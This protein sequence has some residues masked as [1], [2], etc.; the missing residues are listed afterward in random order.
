MKADKQRFVSQSFESL[1][2]ILYIDYFRNSSDF[3]LFRLSKNDQLNRM[4]RLRKKVTRW[5]HY[6]LVQKECDTPSKNTI[7]LGEL[8][9]FK[10]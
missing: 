1:V 5:K 2:F 6:N 9:C 3:R 10:I 4:G 8:E 7:I